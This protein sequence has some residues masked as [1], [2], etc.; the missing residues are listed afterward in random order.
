M[1]GLCQA[2]ESRKKQGVEKK[3]KKKAARSDKEFMDDSDT[4]IREFGILSCFH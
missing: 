3:S 4:D 2:T 1:M